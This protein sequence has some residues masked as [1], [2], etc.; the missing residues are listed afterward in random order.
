M[1]L[2]SRRWGI[3]DVAAT[4]LLDADVRSAVSCWV[5]VSCVPCIFCRWCIENVCGLMR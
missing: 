5:A 1:W 2:Q 3:L 4:V